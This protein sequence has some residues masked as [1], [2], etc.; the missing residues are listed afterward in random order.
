MTISTGASGRFSTTGAQISYSVYVRQP[1][2][3]MVTH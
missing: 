1:R 2:S 3:Q